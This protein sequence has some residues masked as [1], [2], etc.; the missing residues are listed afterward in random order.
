MA[1]ISRRNQQVAG[2]RLLAPS[3]NGTNPLATNAKI[4]FLHHSTG[5]NV[6]GG[7][8]TSGSPG[9]CRHWLD[10]YNVAHSTNYQ[11][12]EM[13]FP[14]DPSGV[15]Y[16]SDNFPYDFWNIWCNPNKDAAAQTQT[17]LETFVT[18]YGR[19]SLNTVLLPATFSPIPAI[20]T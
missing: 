16:P 19:S 8:T 6:W 4:L 11:V 18:Q 15:P 3:G 10:Q 20:L 5:E 17:T 14:G 13:C 9:S 1:S 7:G 12:S 2:H